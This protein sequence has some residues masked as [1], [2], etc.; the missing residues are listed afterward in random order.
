[1]G[2]SLVVLNEA[3]HLFTIGNRHLESI[4]FKGRGSSGPLITPG[5]CDRRICVDV[6]VYL[7]GLCGRLCFLI[8]SACLN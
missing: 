2:Y 8:W 3:P 5:V 6:L 1:M 4:K 7:R